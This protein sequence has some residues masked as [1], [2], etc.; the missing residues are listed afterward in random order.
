MWTVNSKTGKNI[1]SYST[2]VPGYRHFPSF[3]SLQRSKAFVDDFNGDGKPELVADAQGLY[4]WLNLY[5]A[6]GVPQKQ[7]NLGPGKIIRTW[8]TGNFTGDTRP[9]ILVSTWS[10]QL[11]AIDGDCRPLWIADLP[12][13]G[14]AIEVNDKTREIIISDLRNVCKIN[15]SGKL[16]AFV[17]LPQTL[18]QLWVE[19]G[20]VYIL[21]AGTISRLQ[22]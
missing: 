3:G 17:R 1:S 13:K 16:T 10:N 22:L 2:N 5:N 14:T 11:L 18:E 9:E 20:S 12:I 8:T 4:T 21:R 7:V 19:N 15:S 6:Q